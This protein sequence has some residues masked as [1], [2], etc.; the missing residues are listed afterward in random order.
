MPSW[1]YFDPEHKRFEGV[2]TER[3]LGHHYI[4][5]TAH[6]VW[7]S[8]ESSVKAKD[9]FAVNVVRR[10]GQAGSCP[11][12]EDDLTMFSLV[13]D[14]DLNS[15]APSERVKVLTNIAQYLG[16]QQVRI[17][18]DFIFAL[19]WSLTI[20]SHQFRSCWICC[21]D[22]IFNSKILFCSL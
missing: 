11:V 16:I 12:S 5:V 22:Q 7:V 2:P 3:D 19:S 15:L 4:S 10:R 1:L 18:T 17:R 9:A 8:G 14:A 6:G 21:F 13:L 20:S